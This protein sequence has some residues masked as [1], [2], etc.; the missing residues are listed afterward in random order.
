MILWDQGESDNLME[1]QTYPLDVYGNKFKF[2]E[3]ASD[4][5]MIYSGMV[6]QQLQWCRNGTPISGAT[7]NSLIVKQSGFYS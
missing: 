6:H 7:G 3:K 5:V 1:S 4:S 2:C